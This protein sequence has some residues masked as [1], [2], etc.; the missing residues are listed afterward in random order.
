M[1]KT[2]ALLTMSL[3]LVA[4]MMLGVSATITAENVGGYI[5]FDSQEVIDAHTSAADINIS[6]DAE[7][8]ALRYDTIEPAADS[9]AGAYADNNLWVYFA[10]D[11]DG[12][13]VDAA[14]YPYVRVTY[15]IE[16]TTSSTASAHL[17]ANVLKDRKGKELVSYSAGTWMVNRGA[18]NRYVANWSG[19]DAATYDLKVADL[20]LDVPNNVY[21]GQKYTVWIYDVGFFNSV[22][23]AYA[24]S[25]NQTNYVLD[26]TDKAVIDKFFTEKKDG[27]LVKGTS[28]IGYDTDLEA[29]Y[30]LHAA[31][32]SGADERVR[33]NMINDTDFFSADKYPHF[34]MKSYSSSAG[35][36]FYLLNNAKTN[37][38]SAAYWDTSIDI[39]PNTEA[40]KWQIYSIDLSGKGGDTTDVIIQHVWDPINVGSS[41]GTDFIAMKYVA[42]YATAEEAKLESQAAPKTL[43][44]VMPT[45]ADGKGKITGVND[46]MEYRAT[47]NANTYTAVPTGVTEIEVDAGKTYDVRYAAKEGFNAGYAAEVGVPTYWNFNL[48][49]IKGVDCNVTLQDGVYNIEVP[50]G[51][52]LNSVELDYTITTSNAK[53]FNVYRSNGV[54]TFQR[55]VLLYK[56]AE[57]MGQGAVIGAFNATSYLSTPLTLHAFEELALYQPISITF[58]V[59][60]SNMNE[61]ETVDTIL[62]SI[63]STTV[64]SDVLMGAADKAAAAAAI[65]KALNIASI[66]SMYPGAAAGVD[67]VS[68]V[69]AIAGT[70]ADKDGTDG[71]VVYKVYAA[72]GTTEKYSEEYNIIVPAERFRV[73]FMFNDQAMADSI[74]VYNTGIYKLNEN[75]KIPV[76]NGAMHFEI[77][78]A[79]KHDLYYAL[80]KEYTKADLTSGKFTALLD[81]ADYPYIVYGYKSSKY[82]GNHIYFQTDYYI[83]NDNYTGPADPGQA[84]QGAGSFV[85]YT[86]ARDKG[87]WSADSTLFPVATS[88]NVSNVAV[89]NGKGGT[90]GLSYAGN[91]YKNEGGVD[92][93]NANGVNF[94]W[95]GQLSY[96]RSNISKNVALEVGDYYDLEYIAF[97]PSMAALE[98]W[99]GSVATP[100]T[101]DEKTAINSMSIADAEGASAGSENAAKAY[102][103]SAVKT[104]LGNKYAD[105]RIKTVSYTGY[106]LAANTKGSYTFTA[107]VVKGDTL[108]DRDVYTSKEYTIAIKVPEASIANAKADLEAVSASAPAVFSASAAKV[109]AEKAIADVKSTYAG[110]TFTVNA[111]EYNAPTATVAGSLKF[112]VTVTD[113]SSNSA[114]TD[115]LTMTIAAGK[116]PVIYNFASPI[117]TG[118]AF[119][120][121]AIGT[122]DKSL[123]MVADEASLGGAYASMNRATGTSEFNMTFNA[124]ANGN[125]AIDDLGDYPVV[126]YRYK[127]PFHGKYQIYY[128][129]DLLTGGHAYQAFNPS[130]DVNTWNEHIYTVN[131]AGN[132]AGASGNYA[133][134]G[135][136]NRIRFD[137]FRNYADTGVTLDIN[138]IGL[139]ESVE[140]AEAF[141]AAPYLDAD[142]TVAELTTKYADGLAKVNAIETV[143]Y[144]TD[145]NVMTALQAYLDTL[146]LENAYVIYKSSSGAV[147]GTADDIDGT[148][149]YIKFTIAFADSANNGYAVESKELTMPIAA[150]LYTTGETTGSAL[151]TE[152]NALRFFTS[153]AKDWMKVIIDNGSKIEYGT[154]VIPTHMLTGEL[155]LDTE[156]AAKVEAKYIYSQDETEI[157]FTAAVTGIEANGAANTELTARAYAKFTYKGAE[158]VVYFNTV[159]GKL[160]DFLNPAE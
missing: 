12:N 50:Y 120:S 72:I 101:A 71:S 68:M 57:F 113:T 3:L 158:K 78:A 109:L 133:W 58:S 87:F 106:D 14:Q 125:P 159:A 130:K 80:G 85:G 10:Q 41:D 5:R 7:K 132:S 59:A 144:A 148:D 119:Y 160:A 35:K 70:A 94:P 46:T 156:N 149:G 37:N 38:L 115:E 143:P 157:T 92:K 30:F 28:E 89:I 21:K 52:N 25:P 62:A 20:R 53:S 107:E 102:V 36:S 88:S 123:N 134:D 96:F 17:F 155:T 40:E 145:S 153:F 39:R 103:L 95:K 142:T 45:A 122:S 33:H 23:A 29:F 60:E 152:D 81:T 127:A 13:W 1:K 69:P 151:R 11:K 31:I 51:T 75:G 137:F 97:F 154:L 16:S 100:F 47:G 136:L 104:A 147:A 140:Q 19:L 49:G 138:Y 86:W 141:I 146:N 77:K 129:T 27:D 131:P 110:Y 22:E 61:A 90:A 128:Y 118:N 42:Y 135:K 44:G 84:E 74:F 93:Y 91:G 56:N 126:L 98:A 79:G 83:A 117:M 26:L 114:T 6:Y 121:L 99:D 124:G 24:Y 63:T 32:P 67:V 34:S 73:L 66:I 8:G 111:G 54:Q 2:L 150:A 112:T 18:W 116:K 4:A 43:T 82:A 48:K 65:E 139:F 15:Q 9:A 64:T 108:G 76:V 55:K 105:V